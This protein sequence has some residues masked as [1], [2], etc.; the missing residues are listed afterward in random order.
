MAIPHYP[1]LVL[2]MPAPSGTL[3]ICADFKG[4]SKCMQEAMQMALEQNHMAAQKKLK[5]DGTSM[6]QEDLQILTQEAASSA[7]IQPVV[8][9][10]EISLDSSDATKTTAI[11]ALLSP[12][13]EDALVQFLRANRDIFAWK[14]A[15][16]PGV[17]RELA[18]HQFKVFPNAKPIKQR[19]RRF[20]PEK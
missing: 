19:L 17:P 3:S 12:K 15:D 10:K 1:Y 16:M 8:P 7:A 11:N 5:A 2:K 14:P 4:A 9:T 20:T 18:E 13:Q 6:S